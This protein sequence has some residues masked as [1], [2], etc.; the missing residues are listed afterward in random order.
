[1]NWEE[2]LFVGVLTFFFLFFM[3]NIWS[4]SSVLL[5]FGISF[6]V[7]VVYVFFLVLCA[8]LYAIYKIYRFDYLRYLRL[9]IV[10]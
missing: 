1:M 10:C 2:K 3:S 4:F 9:G 6:L 8:L 7:F 5:Y